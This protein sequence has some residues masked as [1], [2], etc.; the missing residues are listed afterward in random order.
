M[1]TDSE[2]Q[3]NIDRYREH[4]EQDR[5]LG[6][7]GRDP[8]C[9][10][11]RR[12][13]S[14]A[15]PAPARS[16]SPTTASTSLATTSLGSAAKRSTGHPVEGSS[17]TLWPVP[18]PRFPARP[19][20]GRTSPTASHPARRSASTSLSRLG[21]IPAGR[22]GHDLADSLV[23]VKAEPANDPLDSVR[24]MCMGLPEV[25]E[26]QSH[27]EP[28]WFVRDKKMF[29]TYADHHHDDRLAFWCAAPE[30]AQHTLT[31]ADPDRYFVPPYVGARGWVGVYLD[32]LPIDWA[33]IQEIIEDAYR[34]VAPKSLASRLG[35]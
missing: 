20:L 15:R 35:R 1:T 6:L 30:G 11:P 13:R 4:A 10:L 26:R 21:P 16:T 33:A 23:R 31:V 19:G 24:A 7:V 27:G 28:A 18:A 12:Q 34:A 17:G 8:Q 22:Q 9:W 2:H 14:P 29:L 3:L 25:S 32:A 5:L